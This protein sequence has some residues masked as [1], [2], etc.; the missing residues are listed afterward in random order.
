MA[1]AAASW[2]LA[3]TAAP[4]GRD[5]RK[6]AANPGRIRQAG[7]R[8]CA[9]QEAMD[10]GRPTDARPDDE[11]PSAGNAEHV[12]DPARR[13]RRRRKKPMKGCCTEDKSRG[14]SR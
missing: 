6:D 7:A 4:R 2:R 11:G 13:P 8:P 1:G 12:R 10:H 9:M 5:R 14:K 3:A